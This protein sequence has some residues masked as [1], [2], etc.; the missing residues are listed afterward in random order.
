MAVGPDENIWFTEG[1]A[2]RIGRIT[3]SGQLAEFALPPGRKPSGIAAGPDGNLWFSERAVNEIGRITPAGRITEFPVPGPSAKLDSIVTGPDGNLWFAEAGASRVGK[4]TPGGRVTQFAVPT[5]SGTS[6]IVSGPGGLVYFISGPE[7]GAI[8]PAGKISWPT[9]PGGRCATSTEALAQ[10]P[11]GRLWIASGIT[12]CAGLC[13]GGTGLYLGRLPGAVLPYVL[14]PLRLAIGPRLTRLRGD[15]TSI[16]LAC[17][18]KSGCLG[19]LRLGWYVVRNHRSRFQPLSRKHYELRRGE[20]RRIALSFS[21][22]TAAYLRKYRKTRLIAIAGD[23]SGP[24]ARRGL[25]LS[26]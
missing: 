2:S 19:T 7:V 10:G 17:G 13:G 5:R 8:S 12:S 16:T 4:I 26:R 14:P 11:D 20:S 3:P 9:C 6:S 22:R 21:D 1:A 23:E 18:L 15:R 25:M 24:L